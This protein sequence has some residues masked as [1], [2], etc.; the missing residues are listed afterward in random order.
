M[1]EEYK[2]KSCGMYR[3]L[4]P[5]NWLF[6]KRYKVNKSCI[7][8]S[9]RHALNPFKV[10][11]KIYV[12][13]I[14]EIEDSTNIF[15]GYMNITISSRLNDEKIS[16]PLRGISNRGVRKMRKRGLKDI[17]DDTFSI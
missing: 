12:G 11:H 1:A 14:K 6:P 17:I 4:H 8:V 2:F 16:I 15:N 9:K 10:D 5:S 3:L 13:N 7:E